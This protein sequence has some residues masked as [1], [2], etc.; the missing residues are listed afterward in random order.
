MDT[1]LIF[2]TYDLCRYPGK[3]IP[4]SFAFRSSGHIARNGSKRKQVER[5]C[6]NTVGEEFLKL[7]FWHMPLVPSLGSGVLRSPARMTWDQEAV[8]SQRPHSQHLNPA[9]NR[10]SSTDYVQLPISS[11]SQAFKSNHITLSDPTD[12]QIGPQPLSA[13]PG[14]GSLSAWMRF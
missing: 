9:R 6:V 3:I 11:V 4:A 7:L 14:D 12:R 1:D 13:A 5:C 2:S 10:S 8:K